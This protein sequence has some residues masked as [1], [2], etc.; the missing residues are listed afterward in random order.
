MCS[1][2]TSRA[3]LFELAILP[4]IG[5]V[6]GLKFGGRRAA[7]EIGVG[8]HLATRSGVVLGL[9]L[10]SRTLRQRTRWKGRTTSSVHSE[11]KRSL[12]CGGF[13]QMGCE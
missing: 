1:A 5:G 9:S 8:D 13:P 3:K 2:P 7:D 10:I 12:G 11:K 4:V 6:V